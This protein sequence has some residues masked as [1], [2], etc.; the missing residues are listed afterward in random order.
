MQMC[1]SFT[2]VIQLNEDY[3]GRSYRRRQW[4]VTVTTCAAVD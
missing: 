2:V 4:P 1:I 3:D